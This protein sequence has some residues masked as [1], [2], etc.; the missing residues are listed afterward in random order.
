M[1]KKFQKVVVIV[2]LIMRDRNRLAKTD[3]L[4]GL[5]NRYGL[6]EEMNRI[7]DRKELPLLFAIMDTIYQTEVGCNGC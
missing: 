1:S 6:S 4:T 5:Y 2:M 3:A 7:Y